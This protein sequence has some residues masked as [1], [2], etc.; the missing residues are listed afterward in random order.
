MTR[1]PVYLQEE[2][3]IHEHHLHRQGDAG[4]LLLRG[5]FGGLKNAALVN[6]IVSIPLENTEY[7][8]PEEGHSSGMVKMEANDDPKG[9]VGLVTLSEDD[10]EDEI[11]LNYVKRTCPGGLRGPS[12]SAAERIA[13]TD[14]ACLFETC[15]VETECYCR[16][17]QLCR[18]KGG[19]G[20]NDRTH[21]RAE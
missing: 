10:V 12:N 1:H 21:R 6:A 15:H 2:V 18:K 3:W 7:Y 9:D 17:V 16:H 11:G 20:A 8:A 14:A 5:E 13:R 4:Q 19:Q